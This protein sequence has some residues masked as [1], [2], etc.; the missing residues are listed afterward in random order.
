M[1]FSVGRKEARCVVGTWFAT[2]VTVRTSLFAM[3]EKKTNF[4]LAGEKV[5]PQNTKHYTF[6]ISG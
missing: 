6:K 5:P 2:V 4:L 3:V 1:S